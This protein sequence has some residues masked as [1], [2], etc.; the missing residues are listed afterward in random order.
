MELGTG[1]VLVDGVDK[2]YL[3]RFLDKV[4]NEA[5][6]NI[7]QQDETMSNENSLIDKN[8]IHRNEVEIK[9]IYVSLIKV[10]HKE[11]LKKN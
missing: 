4:E 9:N 3:N 5:Q 7:D 6:S 2:E 11:I 10:L 8:E 1:K